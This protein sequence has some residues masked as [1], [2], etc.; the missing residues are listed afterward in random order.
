MHIYAYSEKGIGKAENEDRIVIGHTVLSNG[1]LETEYSEG[2]IA[3]ADGVGGNNAGAIASHFLATRLSELSVVDESILMKVN[4]ELVEK[5]RGNES[6][7]NMAS[8]LSGFTING[9]TAHIFHAGNTRIYSL[10]QR[11]YLRRITKDDTVVSFLIESGQLTEEQ[12]QAFD[13]KN[14]I[15]TCFG[16]GKESIL[17]LKTLDEG[18]QGQ[19][20]VLTCD[21]IHDYIT[22]DQ[23]EEML[24]DSETSHYAVL[25]KTVDAAREFGSLDDASIIMVRLQ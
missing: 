1:F 20:I 2:P 3:I 15:T 18:L 19:A 12:A 14:E 24:N 6:L 21:G 22:D 11:G 10:S 17:K 13:R 7:I 5:S 4:T 23:L 8:T 9:S 25:R 16:G